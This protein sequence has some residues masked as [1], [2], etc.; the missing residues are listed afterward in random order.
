[1]E[2]LELR[3]AVIADAAWRW[4]GWRNEWKG[5]ERKGMERNG[6]EWKGMERNGMEWNKAVNPSALGEFRDFFVISTCWP[7]FRDFSILRWGRLTSVN[8]TPRVR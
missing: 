7:D 5:K 2:I 4:T 8:S 1:M 6:K 3:W